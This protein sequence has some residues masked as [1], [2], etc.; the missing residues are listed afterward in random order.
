[1]TNNKIGIVGI[2]GD[3]GSQLAQMAQAANL[4][5]LGCSLSLKNGLTINDLVD[6]CDIVHI[7]AP[8]S[9]LGTLHQPHKSQVVLHDSVMNTSLQARSKYLS[10]SGAIVHMLMNQANTVI[11]ASE[12]TEH[13]KITKH[14]KQLGLHTQT[15]PIAEHDT[16][17]ARSQAPLA[18]LCQVLLPYLFEKQNSGLLT[19]SGELLAQTLHSRQLA[20]T[21]ETTRSILRNPELSALIDDM[22]QAIQAARKPHKPS[23]EK[24]RKK[25]GLYT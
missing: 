21:D 10:N 15:M 14:L 13:A 11:V 18:V 6:Q 24:M 12:S 3:L 1:M 25:Y 8:I 20:W 9:V 5:V 2:T 22:Q 23:V 7:C 4:E 17:M 16:I 19:P